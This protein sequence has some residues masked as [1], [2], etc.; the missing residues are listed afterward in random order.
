MILTKVLTNGGLMK[1]LKKS[2]W[3]MLPLIAVFLAG[4]G[5]DD[6]EPPATVTPTILLT[7]TS[8][9]A[10]VGEILDVDLAAKG[11]AN[12]ATI[13]VK[14]TY[15]PLKINV[16]ELNR[17]DAWLSSNGGSVNQMAFFDDDAGNVKIVLGIFPA[18]CAVGDAS[19]TLHT[20]AKLRIAGIS[21]GNAT[22]SVSV[23][24]AVDSDLGV[25]DNQA[26]LVSGVQSQGLTFSFTSSK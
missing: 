25:F 15:D 14:I 4:C 2:L 5:E 7:C 17:Y 20:I 19:E 13:G 1:L 21:P 18:T 9:N 24:N 11:I 26:N 6:G 12:L 8:T 22:L 23:N 10:V 16:I 3:L